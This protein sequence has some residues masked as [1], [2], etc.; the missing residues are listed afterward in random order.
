[1]SAERVRAAP[2]RVDIVEIDTPVGPGRLFVSSPSGSETRC[3]LILGHGAGGGVEAPD[4]AAL[5][6]LLPPQ[7][8]RVIRFEQPWRTA[9]RKVAVAPPRL[10]EAW[11]A[12]V[13]AV[14]QL[15]APGP[16]Y[17]GGRSAGARVAC[18]TA[19]A[20]QVAGVVC[21]AF[22]LHPPGRPEHSRADELLMP[23]VPRL[24]L[25]GRNDAFGTPNDIRRAAGSD[26]GVTVVGLDGVDH[27]F[28]V[29]RSSGRTAGDV[30][31]EVVATV[32]GFLRLRPDRASRHVGRRE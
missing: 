16:L 10:D 15:P 11:H 17:V 22:P 24:V 32:A 2:V 5:A 27:G 30:T 1:V 13:A 9:G 28:R 6:R 20:H 12:A 4:L 23:T 31:E 14:R 8:A 26:A 19:A 7:G 21:L 29:A 25:Q 3:T 18:R